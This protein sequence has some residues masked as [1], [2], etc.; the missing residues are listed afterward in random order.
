MV[1]KRKSGKGKQ[2]HAGEAAQRP[3]LLG[4]VAGAFASAIID[5][6]KQG[7]K[8]GLAQIDQDRRST[9]VLDRLTEALGTFLPSN[10][11]TP[12]KVMATEGRVTL[13]DLLSE[14]INDLFK[15]HNLPPIAVARIRSLGPSWPPEIA[16]A[17][18]QLK[19]MADEGDTT[20][21]AL[22]IEAINNLFKK[23]RRAP[24]A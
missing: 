11:V 21:Q 18:R 23:H 24:I 9:A 7:V 1:G 2:R 10:V 22:L 6:I 13:S 5:G 12:L 20:V 16:E 15:K 14:A 3:S 4:V 8:Q 19:A 17:S